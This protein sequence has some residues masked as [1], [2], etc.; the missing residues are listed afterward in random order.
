M[1]KTL[2]TH[3]ASKKTTMH[4][5]WKITNHPVPGHVILTRLWD[6]R[7][8]GMPEKRTELGAEAGWNLPDS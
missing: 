3:C 8:E 1:L 7:A 4:W 6:Q 5:S 2:L